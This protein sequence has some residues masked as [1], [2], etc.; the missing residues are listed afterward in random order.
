MNCC[1][2]EFY[3][4]FRFWKIECIKFKEGILLYNCR[5]YCLYFFEVIRIYFVR[6]DLIMCFVI[7]L[8]FKSLLDFV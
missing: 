2:F 1:F 6:R 8:N 7:N 3:N 4:D 5:L